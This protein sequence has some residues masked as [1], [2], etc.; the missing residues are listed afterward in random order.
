MHLRA[1]TELVYEHGGD[2]DKFIGDCIFA[3]FPT[4][5]AALKAA[6]CVLALVARR[7]REGSPFDVRVGINWGRAVRANVGAR[8]RR[9]YTY[10]GDAVNLAQRMEANATPGKSSWRAPAW[11]RL[12]RRPKARRLDRTGQRKGQAVAAF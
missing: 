6:R 5:D 1:A 4:A 12:S 9:E 2:V 8:G 3:A 11:R 7:R 10:I